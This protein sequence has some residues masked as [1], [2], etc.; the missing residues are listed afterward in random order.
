MK[1][2]KLSRRAALGLGIAAVFGPGQLWAQTARPD[3]EGGIG[4]TGIVG[5]LTD[6]G[7]LIVAGNYLRTDAQTRYTDGFGRLSKSDLQVGDSLTVEASGPSNALVARRVHVTH[8]VVG[9]ITARS[10]NGREI[11]VNGVTVRLDQ[12]AGAFGVG[13]RVA[14]S[15]L[16]RGPLVQGARLAPA[17]STQDLVSGDVTRSGG[18]T[19][20]GGVAVRGNGTGSIAPGSFASI[21]GRFNADTGVLQAARVS[22]ARFTGA[23]GALARLSIEGYLDPTSRAPGYRVAGL[24]HSFERNLNLS[25]FATS[26]VL[27]N[28]AY[29][30]RFAAQGAV[31]LPEGFGAQ[32][33][34]L[35]QI[36]QRFR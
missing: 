12:R 23:A 15:G 6:F 10:G 19:R 5:L 30:G 16:W 2:P 7:S 28:G 8:P 20:V 33:R 13:A 11:T 27:L 36:S 35:R 32:R 21:V 9:T 4:G 34:V 18:V 22:N 17:R 3:V 14:V 25:A 24:G 29:T 31:V 26:R 1:T